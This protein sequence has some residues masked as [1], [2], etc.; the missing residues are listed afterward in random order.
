MPGFHQP[1]E[2]LVERPLVPGGE[3]RKTRKH[4]WRGGHDESMVKSA[5][6]TTF[7][8]ALDSTTK[9]RKFNVTLT[10][11]GAAHYLPTGIPDRQL[12][13]EF[14]VLDSDGEIIEKKEELIKRTIVWRPF[15]FDWSD[16][17]LA[18]W[19]PNTFEFS[20]NTK[21]KQQATAVETIVRYHLL[22][23]ARRKRIGYENTTP[24]FY[25]IYRKKILL[26]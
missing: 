5:L 23:E 14:L 11:V 4:L 13:I 2:A 3:V 9:Q 21:N 24:I 26:N 15:I 12:S 19:Q 18:R 6:Q 8:E 16:N 10:N 7:T 20:V 17:R 1:V 25:E 22:P